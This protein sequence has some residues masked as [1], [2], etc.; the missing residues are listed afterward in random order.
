MLGGGAGRMTTRRRS[1]ELACCSAAR[2]RTASRDRPEGTSRAA[3]GGGI[4]R[5]SGDRVVRA[6]RALRASG[7]ECFGERGGVIAALIVAK[8]LAA[9]P[10]NR[11]VVLEGAR[12]SA[13]VGAPSWRGRTARG[14]SRAGRCVQPPVSAPA[15]A[16]VRGRQGPCQRGLTTSACRESSPE[17]EMMNV[18]IPLRE[19]LERRRPRR[20]PARRDR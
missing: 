17:I 9:A 19:G 7:L 20:R 1:G 12:A 18:S 2:T 4:E 10:P 5:G 15:R 11:I 3:G 8:P 16:R 13:A 14:N 6:S